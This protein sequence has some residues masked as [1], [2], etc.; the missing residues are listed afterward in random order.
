VQ[1]SLYGI[2]AVSHDQRMQP[3][4]RSTVAVLEPAAVLD[5]ETATHVAIVSDGSARWAEAHGLSIREGHEAA[6]DT[7]LARIGDAIEFG[8]HQ[9]TLYAFS[10]ENWGRPESEVQE[11]VG[12]LAR[13]I[14]ADTPQ[15]HAQ[16]VRVRFI[17]RRDRAGRALA[18]AMDDAEAMTEDNAGLEVFVA[19]D[20]GGRDQIVRAAE[21][22]RGGGEAEFGRLLNGSGLADPDLVIRT[23]GERRLSNF[24]LWQSAYSELVF[25]EELWPDFDRPALE[26]CLAEYSSRTR[27]FGGRGAPVG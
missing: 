5:S 8:L 6:A 19:F 9:L 7:V 24:L 1:L 14:A 27:R 13:R 4:T 20:Y 18:R 16:D 26:A 17:G 10:T 12:M 15:L 23:S 22:Y 25:R 3:A 11:L 21:R 2:A